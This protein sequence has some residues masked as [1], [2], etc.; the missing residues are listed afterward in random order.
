[1]RSSFSTICFPASAKNSDETK[2]LM[3]D[4]PAEAL[5]ARTV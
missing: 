3:I 4:L 5:M 2:G 1:M